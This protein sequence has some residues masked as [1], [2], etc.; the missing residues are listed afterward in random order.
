MQVVTAT[1]PALMAVVDDVAARALAHGDERVLLVF[2]CIA[3]MDVLAG[4]HPEEV[5][6][7]HEAAGGATT[8]GFYTYGE[9]A[10]TR[11]LGGVHNATLTA[12]AL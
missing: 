10:R 4:A 1:P 7:L 11:G 2:D 5:R 12:I 3:R 6:R 8:F 9:F